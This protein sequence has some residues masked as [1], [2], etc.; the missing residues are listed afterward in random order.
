MPPPAALELKIDVRS[1][2]I[3]YSRPLKIG[4]PAGTA[5]RVSLADASI[6]HTPGRLLAATPLRSLLAKVLP[7]LRRGVM[8]RPRLFKRMRQFFNVRRTLRMP[9][10]NP[11]GRRTESAN[12]PKYAFHLYSP[13][14]AMVAIAFLQ[15]WMLSAPDWSCAKS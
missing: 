10:E 4:R 14:R 12:G 2:R 5:L 1:I 3:G 13:S 7:G 15:G 8:I 11:G 9:Y 6:Q